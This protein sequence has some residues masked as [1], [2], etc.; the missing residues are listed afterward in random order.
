MIDVLRLDG[1][2]HGV[3]EDLGEVILKVG[4]AK[5]DEDLLP[6][7]GRI[8]LAEVGLHLSGED[9]EG[10][11][12]ADAVGTDEAEDLNGAGHGKPMELEGVGAIS[13]SGVALQIL[14]KVDDGN[15]L[16]GA[17]LDADTA[18]WVE[19]RLRVERRR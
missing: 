13:V 17:L 16:E 4:S 15:G 2:L 6:I 8:I 14:G 7:G 12:L 10:G 5:V 11:T 1:G 19:S 18:S 9:L 3:L